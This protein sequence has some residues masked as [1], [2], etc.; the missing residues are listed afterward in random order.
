MK[1]IKVLIWQGLDAPINN[2]GAD[3]VIHEDPSNESGTRAIIIINNSTIPELEAI[4][5]DEIS[6]TSCEGDFDTYQDIEDIKRGLEEKFSV[7]FIESEMTPQFIN[8]GRTFKENNYP[9]N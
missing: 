2:Y 8:G 6:Y 7:S 4:F 1:N 5:D 3:L 9:L